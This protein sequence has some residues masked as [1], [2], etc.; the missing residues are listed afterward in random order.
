MSYEPTVWNNG[1]IITAEKLNKLEN[2]VANGDNDDEAFI[3]TQ[4]DSNNN[5]LYV[6]KT[7]EEIL[8]AIDDNKKLVYRFVNPMGGNGAIIMF[9]NVIQLRAIE[10]NESIPSGA[11]NGLMFVGIAFGTLYQIT[12]SFSNQELVIYSTT[13]TL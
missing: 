10:N 13:K 12:M 9:P 5:Q 3:I 11:V 6:D 1:D 4:T 7:L 8:Q 2:G